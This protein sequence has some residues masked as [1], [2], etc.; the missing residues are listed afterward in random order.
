MQALTRYFSTTR[1]RLIIV[2]IAI[3]LVAVGTLIFVASQS[4]E[5]GLYRIHANDEGYVREMNWLWMTIEGDEFTTEDGLAYVNHVL[6]SGSVR[7][8]ENT[9]H[10]WRI[11]HTGNVSITVD[12][13]VIFEVGTANSLQTDEIT[14]SVNSD[15]SS[16]RIEADVDINTARTIYSYRTEFGIYEQ[17]TFG[18]WRLIPPHRLYRGT[19]YENSSNDRQMRHIASILSKTILVISAI[20]LFT[21]WFRQSSIRLDK[22]TWLVIGIIS[23]SL[24]VR[25]IVM[26]ERFYS[27]PFFHFM[28]PAGDDNYVLMGQ[29]LLAGDY[30]LAG[31][32]WPSA[33]IV[34]FA[35]IVALLGPQLWKIYIANILLSGLATGA[36]VIGAWQAFDNRRIGIISG[37][38]FALYPPLIFYQVTP[39]SV[40]LDSALASFALLFGVLAV[41]RE[42]FAYSA[43]FGVMIA[44][45]GMSR[46]T[47]LLLGLAFFIAL[48][49]KKP[50]KG[51]QLTIIAGI[52]SLLTL[53]P[54]NLA[55]FY[56]TGDLSL[57]PYSNGQLT[58][59]SG[60]NR[61]ADGIWTGRGDA[62][63]ITRLT[64]EHWTEAL[65]ADFQ[66]D[67]IRMLELNLRK[68]SMFWNNHEY[69]SNVNYTQQ[70]IGKSRLISILSLDGR[71]GMASLSFF[72]FIG[73][74]LLLSA[75]KRE[76]WFIAWSIIMLVFGT[77]LFVL[78]GRL[79]I[80]VL[81]FLVVSAGVAFSVIWDAIST[82]KVS[83][84]LLT[85]IAIAIGLSVIFPILDST[86]PRKS[87]ITV[88]DSAID[89]SYDFNNE[90][91]LLGFDPI[92]TNYSE[93]GYF[94]ISLYWQVLE[95]ATYDYRVI[96]ELA[97]ENGR[98]IGVDRELGSITYPPVTTTNL[99]IGGIIQEGY[100]LQLPDN[101]PEIA[102]VNVG[103]YTDETDELLVAPD[104]QLVETP[105]VRLFDVALNTETENQQ[106][107]DNQEAEYYYFGN[108][109]IFS[110]SISAPELNAN[111]L[112]LSS[113]WWLEQQVYEDYVIFVQVL[114]EDNILV[115]QVD[116][117][118]FDNGRTI[119]S[120]FG[121]RAILSHEIE[122][123]A[124][125]ADG[126][127][128][129]I[130]GMYSFPSIERLPAFDSDL[131]ALADAII[132]V[133]TITIGR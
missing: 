119:S 23:L 11:A 77:A 113:E 102:S 35:G 91:R 46:G 34:W 53:L 88:P 26:A 92:Q 131:Q 122:L 16:I 72:V 27:D 116:S 123:P 37:L 98:I 106:I 74:V 61:D 50:I 94:Y 6:I 78:A 69:V 101:L 21:I 28:V 85:A 86:L 103:I 42:S 66:Q 93:N 70:G 12:D 63:E 48:L 54:Q 75:G 38:L 1:N 32:F 55:N 130:M 114:D 14:F 87:F 43:L 80:P 107:E 95:Q 2:L 5:H 10:T 76:T 67:P 125:L 59:Y 36:V 105:L 62:W 84:R 57:V 82:R 17:D 13:T 65:I 132:P 96:V 41:K 120:L 129:V 128:Q 68:L 52:V 124:N 18:R 71:L 133:G 44:L 117:P 29:Q 51:I 56:A 110:V 8:E 81:P 108:E 118:F 47:A 22:H 9:Q 127:Y 30:S 31:T 40:V 111:T 97:D 19:M 39:Q 90:I 83:T 24:T 115:T 121:G 60:N 112:M 126:T 89:R 109:Q 20:G 64:G 25:F 45:G 15:W 58:L 49:I 73:M 3:I 100:L 33:P 99:P 79:R 104:G 7:L 4:D